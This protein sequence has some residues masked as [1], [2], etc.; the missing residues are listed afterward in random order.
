[1][2]AQ[3]MAINDDQDTLQMYSDLL[4]YEG[5]AVACYQTPDLALADFQA[6]KPDLVIL[7][8]FFDREPLGARA[9]H[10]LKLQPSTTS[11]PVLICTVATKTV[12][13]LEDALRAQGIGVVYKPF[14]VDDFL[15][16]IATALRGGTSVGVRP[17][18][19]AT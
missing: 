19:P 9:L 3:I 2:A 12:Q 4:T 15:A 18:D 8:W 5:Y 10:E 14:V 13:E 6:V 1:M 16:A 11:I 17:T 7:D